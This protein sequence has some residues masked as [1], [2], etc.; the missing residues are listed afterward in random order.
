[1]VSEWEV[2]ILASGVGRRLRNVT[3]GLPKCFYRVKGIPLLEYPLK[4]IMSAVSVS[5]IDFIIPDSCGPQ[6]LEDIDEAVEGIDSCVVI[7]DRVEY[8]NAYSLILAGKCVRS[9]EFIVSVCD[10]LYTPQA[11]RRLVNS[12]P[13]DA[14]VVV[15]GS[16]CFKYVD[17]EEATK[18]VTDSEGR[19]LRIG[20]G[21]RSFN[22][23]DT[24]LFIMRKSVFSMGELMPWGSR[25]LSIFDLLSKALKHGLRVYAANVGSDPWTEVDTEDDLRELISGSRSEVLRAVRKGVGLD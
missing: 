9:N 21:L 5:R 17:V 16:E 1:M 8:G 22:L 2:V 6:C 11:V 4:S 20:K 13:R 3:G 18:I 14:D 12:V 24:G 10:S 25:E 15:A 7:N 19:V 23:I